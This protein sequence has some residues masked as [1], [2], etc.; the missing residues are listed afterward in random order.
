LAVAVEG[1]PT[2]DN[3]LKVGGL[4]QAGIGKY[5]KPE[6]RCRSSDVKSQVRTLR[7]YNIIADEIPSWIG[8]LTQVDG[9]TQDTA[10]KNNSVL[11]Q[12][13]T[14]MGN[15]KRLNTIALSNFIRLSELPE[16]LGSLSS[17][18]KLDLR[19]CDVLITLPVCLDQWTGMECLMLNDMPRFKEM[20]PNMAVIKNL[21]TL[22]IIVCAISN[23]PD[24]IGVLTNLKQLVVGSCPIS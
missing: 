8:K 2:V 15:M 12:L 18:Q 21:H 7:A 23:I 5:W 11:T 13:P 24:S 16:I 9:S 3:V 20:P 19:E 14:S 10:G 22:H 4:F 1:I 6:P 17:L